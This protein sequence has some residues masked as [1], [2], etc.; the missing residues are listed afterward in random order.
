[1]VPRAA[2]IGHTAF[3][4]YDGSP[5]QTVGVVTLKELLRAVARNEPPVLAALM[6]PPIFVPETAR[7]SALLREL[8]RARYELAMVVD[9]YGSLVGLVTIEDLLEEIVGEIHED[10][11]PHHL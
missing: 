7:I 1:V 4:V 10:A 2:E 5:D 8:Q 3:P 9:E 11:P 6:E